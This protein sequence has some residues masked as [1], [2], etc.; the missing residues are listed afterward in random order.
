MTSPY[1]ITLKWGREDESI[2]AG[3]NAW[4]IQ[5]TEV[6]LP[7]DQTPEK[8]KHAPRDLPK[9]K[10]PKPKKPPNPNAPP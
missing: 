10:A 2:G 3:L 5:G 8:R 7:G 4:P 1:L 9:N 6:F